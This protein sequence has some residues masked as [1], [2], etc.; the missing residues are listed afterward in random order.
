MLDLFARFLAS[1]AGLVAVT[2]GLQLAPDA[3]PRDGLDAL[4]VAP[5][6]ALTLVAEAPTITNPT[7]I[8]VD[9][10][11]RIWLIEGFNY[12]KFKPKPLRAAGDRIVILEDTTGDG[13]AD[14]S[15]VFYQGTDIDAAMGIAVLGNKV[16]VSAYTKIFVFTDTNGDDKPDKKEVLF[17][18]GGPPD[19]DH[20]THA[21]VFGP[22]GRLYF[23]GG[24]ETRSIM[25][26]AG[27]VLVDRA[28]HR[29]EAKLNPYQEGMAFRLEPD[30][31]KF[32]VLGYNFRN[33]YELAVDSYGTVWQTDNDDDGNRSTRL[34]YVMEGGNF[35]YRDEMTGAFW[36]ARRTG[37]EPEIPRQHW[38]SA[39]PGSVPNVRINGAGSP[40]GVIVYEGSLL[41]KQ[42]QGTIIHADPGPNEV[43]AFTLGADGAG[44]SAER[45]PIITSAKD[46]MFRPVDVAVAPDGSLF[47]ADWYDAGVG[48]HNMSDQSQGRIIRIAPPG[49]RYTV[50]KLDLSTPI[51]ATRALRSPNLA[52]RHLAY[53]R[54]AGDGPR[55]ES[56]LVPMWR[57]T[58]PHERARALWL[59]AR[60]PGRGA[61]YLSEASRDADPNIR[62]T[63]LRATRRI[64]G[65]VIA[66]AERLVRDPS[67]AVRRE[68]AIALRH[69]QSR[70][71]GALW[72]GL[73]QQY[74]GKDRWYLEALGVA[75]D[76]QW[77]RYF[78]AWLDRIGDDWNTAAGRDIVWRA[79]SSRA[80]PLL[81]QLA[82]DQATPVADRIR[83]FRA[84]DFHPAE[85]RQKSLLALLATPAG[86]SAELTPVILSQLDAKTAGSLPEVQ[87]ALQRSLGPLRGTTQY[88][89]LVD[90]HGVRTELDELVK[91]ALAKPN[92]TVGS[93]AARL[94]LSW[95]ALPRFTEIVRGTDD[96][97]ARRALVVLGRN[98][99]PRVD[100]IM[101]AV[102]LD[103]TRALDLRRQAVQS[104][105]TGNDGWMRLIALAREK[106]LPK[107]LEPAA[108]AALFA[109]WPEIRDSAA[110]YLPTPPATTLDGKTLPSLTVLAA[111]TGDAAAGRPVFE[112]S[113]S[114]CHV[115]GGA[116]TDFGPALTEIGDKLP[117]SGLYHAILDPSA[118][119]AFGY[120][121]WTIK[122]RDGQQLVGMIASETDDEVVLKLMGG[123]QR[124]VPKSTIAERK[125]MDT[126][127]M[128]HGLERTMNEADLV[129]L[130]EYL[131][132]L[133]RQR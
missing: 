12:R 59:L 42:Y 19:H 97:A 7:N 8:D 48:G 52:T 15:T 104:M 64:D 50:P 110:K 38:H 35:G 55:A 45:L 128:P 51:A 49:T 92:E 124:R 103:T 22:D 130:V 111:R 96:A 112:R 36:R 24:N 108:S 31:S 47:V 74:D 34:N 109:A 122:T 18:A 33:P 82:A 57:G 69:N 25:D 72:A 68:V 76:R 125:R 133:R 14:K 98:F 126:S 84:L 78:G 56:A 54:L 87:A 116:G 107:Q 3:P 99:T 90:R 1:V 88:V 41:P 118:G 80:L 75:A 9:A 17:T 79:R 61:R 73:A 62:I 114:S 29:V 129:H 100:T 67:P 65:D 53:E 101:T 89:D 93:E 20:S 77:D 132:T 106:R 21:F 120:E 83:Y 44:Y 10:R 13:V 127:L 58:V 6:L 66:M 60:I 37:M 71:A 4:E 94:A 16:Y 95:G 28:G 121:G 131:S 32:E 81:E 46:K 63:A 86:A 70:R 30:G 23:N 11:G 5:G 102:V 39:D 117:K 40:A 119:I 91:L 43:R 26:S 2:F 105:G 115:V 123:I 85:A 113:C 27:K